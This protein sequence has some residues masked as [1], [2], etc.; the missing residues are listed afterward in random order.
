MLLPIL[1][2]STFALTSRGKSLETVAKSFRQESSLL[3]R[4]WVGMIK[5]RMS[6][7][8]RMTWDCL[9][10]QLPYWMYYVSTYLLWVKWKCPKLRIVYCISQTEPYNRRCFCCCIGQFVIKLSHLP[11]SH[12]M[13]PVK[14]SVRKKTPGLNGIYLWWRKH[15]Y[16]N[17]WDTIGSFSRRT[18]GH[19]QRRFQAIDTICS[20]LTDLRRLQDMLV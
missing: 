20:Q 8:P 6:V 14:T 15:R 10:L 1:H 11:L 18:V 7:R 5:E 19:Y 9:I 16:N 4:M 3:Y 13:I 12:L 2:I 17:C